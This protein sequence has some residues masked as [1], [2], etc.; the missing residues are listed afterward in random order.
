MEAEA[1]PRLRGIEVHPINHQGRPSLLLRDPLQLS[2]KVI[3]VPQQ[4][5]PALALC[6]GRHEVSAIHARLSFGLGLRIDRET[7]KNFV[8]ALDGALLLE[9]ER[10]HRAY[11][12]ALAAYRQAP[13]RPPHLAGKSYPA[14][15]D[16]L[17]RKL[18]E[19]SA[20]AV[21]LPPGPA[22]GRGLVSPHIDYQRGGPTYARIWQHS[23]EMARAADLAI[24]LGTDHCG[25]DGRLTLTRQHYA[26]PLGALPTA[27]PIV[28]EIA[29]A[30]GDEAAFG[31]ELHHQHEHSIELAAVWLHYIRE[32]AGCEVVP[33][34]CGSFRHF[35][36]GE[37]DPAA[38]ERIETV[39]EHLRQAMAGRRTVVVAAADLAH[40]GPAF[41]G[42]PQGAW[43]QAQLRAADAAL[44]DQM[45]HGSA[46]G[47]L[48]AIRQVGDRYNVCGLPPI[49]IAMRILGP[50]G[51]EQIAYAHCPADAQGT[52]WVSICGIA[53]Q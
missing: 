9:N 52:S 4:L 30:I 23:A 42:P 44:I 20:Q 13:Y 39:V 43:E 25:G 41:D 51:G 29:R 31:E 16:E 12:D 14:E 40:V 19:Y 38:D 21:D 5:A 46:D 53:W 8:A 15:A 50:G 45:C 48:H 2:D 49:Y 10:F 33:I 36:R 26:T 47:F 7:V 6:D 35:V 11:R 28:D 32:G 1:R 22:G 27:Q 24:V 17:R 18:S 3:V 34:L 37:A